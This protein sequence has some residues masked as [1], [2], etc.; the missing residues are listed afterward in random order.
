MQIPLELHPDGGAEGARVAHE[1]IDLIIKARDGEALERR[2]E[3]DLEVAVVGDILAP[4]LRCQPDFV[5][6]WLE[7][8]AQQRVQ[9]RR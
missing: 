2:I 4:D 8:R 3:G 6:L 1:R 9:G 5:G 7:V